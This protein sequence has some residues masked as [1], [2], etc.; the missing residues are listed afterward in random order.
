M[1]ITLTIR[2]NKIFPWIRVSALSWWSSATVFGLTSS[3]FC[4]MM[5][6]SSAL[7]AATF[8]PY[9]KACS[10]CVKSVYDLVSFRYVLVSSAWVTGSFPKQKHKAMT[11]HPAAFHLSYRSFSS[12]AACSYFQRC[13]VHPSGELH[14]PSQVTSSS[15]PKKMNHFMHAPMTSNDFIHLPWSSNVNY[16]V[17]QTKPVIQLHQLIFQS[18]TTSPK[19]FFTLVVY[20]LLLSRLS[21]RSRYHENTIKKPENTISIW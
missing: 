12:L 3:P 9:W 17:I 8:A 2:C 5:D 4:P 1:T 11:G 19:S 7:K 10:N 6:A 16:Y 20:C 13:L 18:C 21:A 14:A 15:N